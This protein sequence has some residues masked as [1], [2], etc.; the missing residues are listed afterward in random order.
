MILFRIKILIIAPSNWSINETREFGAKILVR[1]S[2]QLK[3]ARSILVD[4][5]T[6]AGKI[7]L[8]SIVEKVKEFYNN[9]YSR[10]IL[11]QK[12]YYIC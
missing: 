1:K 4:T 11:G 9:L 6:K 7:L 10:I 2:K 12:R 5:T 8:D 3:D